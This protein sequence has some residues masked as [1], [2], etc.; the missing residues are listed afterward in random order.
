[1]YSGSG[2]KTD[3]VSSRWSRRPTPARRSPRSAAS[4]EQLS[5]G[6]TPGLVRLSVGIEDVEDLKADLGAGF[7]AVKSALDAKALLAA[8]Y[9]G[10]RVLW[11]P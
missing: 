8:T 9:E 4:E 11:K 5:T 6:T 7:R 3:S 2:G 10:D 1:M